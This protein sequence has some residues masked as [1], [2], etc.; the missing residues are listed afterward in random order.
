MC[1]G[2]RVH[3]QF[4]LIGLSVRVAVYTFAR[5]LGHVD[6]L[7]FAGKDVHP[8]MQVIVLVAS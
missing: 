8:Q 6:D 1:D 7:G 2:V 5:S 3:A 4:I